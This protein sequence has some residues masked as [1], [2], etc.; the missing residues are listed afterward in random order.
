VI[1]SYDQQ[2]TLSYER[3]DE[4]KAFNFDELVF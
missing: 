4:I 2:K 3:V 1:K